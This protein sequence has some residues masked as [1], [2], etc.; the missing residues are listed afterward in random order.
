MSK[1]DRLSISGV[2]AFHPMEY[3]FITFFTPL[4]LI[5][6]YNGSG[7]T[8]IIECLKYATTG[9]LPPN[10]KGG[11][12]IHD[13]KL[14]G[15]REVRAQVKLRISAPSKTSYTITRSLQLEVKRT[16]RSMKTLGGTWLV[17]RAGDAPES[18]NNTQI[19]LNQICPQ[20]LGV[21]R[22]I[23]DAVIFCHQDESLWP[24]SEPSA[25]KKR[26]DEIFEAEKY[27]KAIDSIKVLRKK[28]GDD[29]TKLKQAE[30]QD[31]DNKE[32]AD[33]CEKRSIELQDRIDELRNQYEEAKTQ[34]QEAEE[35]AKQKHIQAESF[36]RIVTD[37][38]TK[39]N[40][41]RFRQDNLKESRD[42]MEELDDSDEMLQN[43][44][45]RYEERVARHQQDYEEYKSQYKGLKDELEKK[46]E[47]KS[48]KLAEQGKLQSDKE[49]YER[50]LEIRVDIIYAAAQRH[51]I[52]GFDGK[53]DERKAQAFVERI[54]DLLRDKKREFDHM[55]DKNRDEA[56]RISGELEELAQRKNRYTGNRV[57]AN[58][59]IGECHKRIGVLQRDLNSIEAD[60]GSK[61]LL[62]T[63]LKSL[64]QQIRQASQ[65][66]ENAEFDRKLQYENKQADLL[67]VE[68]NG[69][70]NQLI[71]ATE[72]VSER[73]QLDFQKAELTKK[74][75]KLTTL[76][77]S[78][79]KN[80]NRLIGTLWEPTTIEREFQ[81]AME[82]K[83]R[84]LD[85]AVQKRDNVNQQYKAAQAALTS[86]TEASIKRNNEI[87][88]CKT[89]VLR[90]LEEARC[91]AER[92][93]LSL[94][95]EIEY[96]E[97]KILQTEKDVFVNE[98]LFA[99]Y[100]DCQKAMNKKNKCEL[101][102]RP[103]T[104]DSVKAKLAAKIQKKLDKQAQEE[105]KEELVELEE[106]LGKLRAVRPEQENFV[107]LG[108]EKTQ[109]NHDLEGSQEKADSLS[110][111]LED[112]DQ[113][114]RERQDDRRELEQMNGDVLKISQTCRDI[115]E[116]ES[117]VERVMS[118]QHSGVAIQSPQEIRESQDQCVEKLKAVQSR[119]TRLGNDKQRMRD[120]ITQLEHQ[121]SD[122][123]T[124]ISSVTGQL[125]KK[126]YY[127]DQISVQR[128]DIARQKEIVQQA[129]ADL[130]SV[131]PE[132]AKFRTIQRD[133]DE[134]SRAKEKAV[135]DERDG[136]ATSVSEL[137]RVD[138]DIQSY[139][140]RGGES[141]LGRNQRA[142]QSLEKSIK[143]TDQNMTELASRTN[144]LKE[145]MVN[146]DG[147]KRN[148]HE[149]LTYR[150]T[151]REVDELR[152]EIRE[153]EARNADEDYE[154]L[155]AEAMSFETRGHI[156][157]AEQGAMMGEMK[158]KDEELARLLMEW[159]IDYKDAAQKYRET[160]IKLETTRAAIEDL[161]CYSQA[162]SNAIMKYH[163]LKMEEVNRI[164]GE[165]WRTTYQG[166]DI[167]TILIR[168]D[169]EAKGRS[170]Y[171]YRVCMVK[172]DTEMDMRGRCSAGQKVLASIIIRL[173]LAE[174]FGIGC[175][176]IA[177]DE[178]TTNLD[179]DNIRS[180]AESL[181]KIIEVRRSQANFQLI[182]ITHDE[183][184]L[185]HMRCSDFVDEFY[186]VSRDSR[187][188]S[189][190]Q[191][192]GIGMISE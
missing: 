163:A 143:Q 68:N 130:E 100:Q 138:N 91:P 20:S 73:A 38:A 124:E 63:Q 147:K 28:K 106:H 141:N 184:F 186:R 191:R 84:T 157:S 152:R 96:L 136:L 156:L 162:L 142:I 12:F 116:S 153:L 70:R 52:R 125:E 9:D 111:Q 127:H 113:V 66:L 8:T 64:E 81:K 36:H 53:I 93:V 74:K 19:D 126:Q 117:Q 72:A 80:L 27:T 176:I 69:L 5:V 51:N 107:R 79:S 118:Q 26:F 57:F 75:Q 50:Q 42:R 98:Q 185:R 58:Q 11:A 103:L 24:M 23:L 41:L 155:K 154:R 1:I 121:R 108:R 131:E 49:H 86:A 114:V 177:L 179:R 90:A 29:L 10:S 18:S 110:R 55:Q 167:D 192:Q 39:R 174:S 88:R 145:E 139:V 21:S 85:D 25:L 14:L 43:T 56:K 170:S 67:Q 15:E 190:I 151:L 133:T 165:L 173:A 144:S 2:R 178:P 30:V 172:Q 13:P 160:H 159:E 34:M 44:L 128:E 61:A 104:D 59:R 140:E 175:G 120:V 77:E 22:A 181:H 171:N 168:S 32:K 169:S 148:I 109:S 65:E 6:G 95:D 7:K 129:D 17:K 83:S 35:N 134:K 166:T 78:Y 89:A 46:H 45:E 92:G 137:K 31:K 182:V 112:L 48:G 180:L 150:K 97:D 105:L 149:N 115:Q 187:Q 16:T 54:E 3:Q 101:C 119:I 47:E 99:Y 132:I 123:K 188:N 135:A 40:E 183:D 33:R 60:E 4:T 146:S 158:T 164:A 71:E 82:L 94:P 122:L 37:I 62:D 87:E 102:E 76:T 189:K 161:G